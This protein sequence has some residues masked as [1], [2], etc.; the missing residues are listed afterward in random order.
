MK[1]GN[2]S[3]LLRMPDIETIVRKFLSEHM[4][5]P[6][7]TQLYPPGEDENTVGKFLRLEMSGGDKVDIL[8]PN[9]LFD[10][11]IILHGYSTDETEA[12]SINAEATGY[13]L[14]AQGVSVDGWYVARVPDMNMPH[15]LSDR[16]INMPRYRSQVTWTVQGKPM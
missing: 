9:P 12:M 11:D 3:P 5:I 2:V 16:L 4:D 15:R 10:C 14:A 7:A 13:C 1:P 8:T 6:I